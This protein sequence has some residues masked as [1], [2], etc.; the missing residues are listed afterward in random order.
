MKFLSSDVEKYLLVDVDGVIL[1][2]MTSFVDYAEKSGYTLVEG[3]ESM[4][5][6]HDM[7][8][9]PEDIGEALI[10]DFLDESFELEPFADVVEYLPEIARMGYVVVGITAIGIGD[11]HDVI[12]GLDRFNNF[13][14]YQRR[15]ENIRS[16]IGDYMGEL[17]LT[18]KLGS[19]AEVLSEYKAD[20]VIWVEDSV[21]NAEAGHMLG[22]DT[23]LVD[24][25]YNRVQMSDGI[26]RVPNDTPWRVIYEYC[27]DYS[28]S[29]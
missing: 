24:H 1:D 14:R 20:H 12:S 16:K 3:Y 22:L 4:T 17:R 6:V 13:F 10:D 8:G 15:V 23:F 9:C 21:R 2:F 28:S 11:M 27:R 7:V 18:P 26:K 29:S 19:K 25:P 5:R